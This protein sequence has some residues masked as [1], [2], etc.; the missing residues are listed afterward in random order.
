MDWLI[1]CLLGFRLQSMLEE[2]RFRRR[3]GHDVFRS[4]KI[5]QVHRHHF[6]P[7]H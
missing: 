4:M 7:P 2:S 1:V 3:I 6:H 5:S